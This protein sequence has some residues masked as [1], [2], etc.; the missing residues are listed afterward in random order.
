MDCTNGGY[1]GHVYFSSI[2][3]RTK[4]LI[5]KQNFI[6]SFDKKTFKYLEDL[7]DLDLSSN[8]LQT[9]DTESPFKFEKAKT[10]QHCQNPILSSNIENRSECV[11]G[12]KA[13]SIVI[14]SKT[15]EWHNCANKNDQALDED[16]DNLSKADKSIYCSGHY[17]LLTGILAVILTYIPEQFAPF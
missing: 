9:L 14:D 15:Y 1:K 2:P 10:S 4:T 16:K 7:V 13:V 3:D 17:C 12:L 11:H 5:L 6:S 8:D